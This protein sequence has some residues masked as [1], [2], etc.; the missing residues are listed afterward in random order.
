MKSERLGLYLGIII[1]IRTLIS[2]F[3][4]GLSYLLYHSKCMALSPF[5]YVGRITS[6]V[7]VVYSWFIKLDFLL[8]WNSNALL[9]VPQ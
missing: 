9:F 2:Y 4:I 1:R 6:C 8:F 7:F 5:A 3:S